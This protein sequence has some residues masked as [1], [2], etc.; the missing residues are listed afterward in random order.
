MRESTG[1]GAVEG[2]PSGQRRGAHGMRKIKHLTQRAAFLR[3]SDGGA[4][5]QPRS[6]GH[7]VWRGT[8]GKTG[9]MAG[10]AAG[11]P[12]AV[13]AAGVVADI[14]KRAARLDKGIQG[15]TVGRGHAM[16][17]P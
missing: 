4:D 10:Q 9:D 11:Q 2:S 6:P 1:K 14:G 15:Q 13:I 7:R 16:P 12:G 5:N 8:I 17:G 3:C